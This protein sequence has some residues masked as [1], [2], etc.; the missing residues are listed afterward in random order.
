MADAEYLRHIARRCDSLSRECFD[1]KT[2]ERLR[3]LAEEIRARA[4]EPT[5]MVPPAVLCDGKPEPEQDAG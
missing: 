4:E 3:L 1:L 2:A 5:I